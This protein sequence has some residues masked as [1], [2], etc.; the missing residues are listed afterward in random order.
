MFIKFNRQNQ[1]KLNRSGTLPCEI[2]K[3][4]TI[5]VQHH[6]HGRNI[7][8]ANSAANLA[9][10]CPNCHNLVHNNKIIVENKMLTSIGYQLIWHYS[11]EQSISGIDAKPW[12]I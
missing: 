5:L 7:P 10:I 8:N 11:T 3:E 1:R 12:L 6:I 9:N 4:Y 2:C